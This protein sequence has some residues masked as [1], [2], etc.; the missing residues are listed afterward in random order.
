MG[1]RGD[2]NTSGTKDG[3]SPLSPCLGRGWAQAGKDVKEEGGRG[4]QVG[5]P[6]GPSAERK[7][8]AGGRVGGPQQQVKSNQTSRGQ[9]SPWG[10]QQGS[11]DHPG[12]K[13]PG[14]SVARPQREGCG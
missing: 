14:R 13:N 5:A 12:L 8:R 2:L 10:W 1:L 11:Q 9:R 6:G 3:S 4:P 7:V